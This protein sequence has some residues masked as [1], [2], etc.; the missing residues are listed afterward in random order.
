MRANAAQQDE[1]LSHIAGMVEMINGAF[2]DFKVKNDAKIEALQAQSDALEKAVAIGQSPGVFM[3]DSNPLAAEKFGYKNLG[4][5]ALDIRNAARPGAAPTDGLM[6]YIQA[7][8]TTF[9]TEGSGADGGVL[10]PAE[11][12]QQIMADSFSDAGI[13]GRCSITTVQ[14]NS[15]VMPTDEGTPWSTTGIRAYWENEAATLT[16]SKPELKTVTQR[17]GKITALVPVS[18]ELL[19]DASTLSAYLDWKVREIFDFK[20]ALGIVQGT[21]TGQPMGILNAGGLKT[22]AKETSQVQDTILFENI[23]KMEAAMLPQH[24]KNAVVLAHSTCLPQLRS[25]YLATGDGGVPAYLPAGGLADNP[26]DRLAGLPVIYTEAC[27]SLG[28]AGDIILAD[29]S[30]Y[31]IIMKAAG[32]RSDVS[33]H[34]WFDQGLT[35]FRFVMRISGQPWR[36]SVITGRDGST[37]YSPFVALAERASE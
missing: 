36:S 1:G 4:A 25:M 2:E 18:D 28:D 17:L 34:V 16:Q 13:L 24:R 26:Y 29:L 21:G 14:G 10:V 23:A 27:N 35:A 15:Y 22:I 8:A 5:M 6:G 37:E 30:Q 11:F 12:S 20:I 7:A 9:G 31:R 33:M 19:E 3:G 32:M